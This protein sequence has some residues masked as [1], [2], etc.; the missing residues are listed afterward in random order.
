M[1]R[2]RGTVDQ[3]DR[4]SMLWFHRGPRGTRA[5]AT[6][7]NTNR[8]VAEHGVVNLHCRM[9]VVVPFQNPLLLTQR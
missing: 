9:R 7:A 2:Q 1:N 4:Y 3:L 8:L 6:P 5:C